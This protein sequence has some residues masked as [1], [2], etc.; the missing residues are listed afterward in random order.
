MQIHVSSF[1]HGAATPAL[2]KLHRHHQ[3][4]GRPEGLRDS[5]YVQTKRAAIFRPS[6]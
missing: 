6:P 2:Q 3:I 1:C 4:A 5:G